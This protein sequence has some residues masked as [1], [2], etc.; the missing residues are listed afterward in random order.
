M[1]VFNK[2]IRKIHLWLGL[3]CGLIA[4]FSGLTGALYVWQ[5][6]ITGILNPGLLKVEQTE[7][8][9]E[10]VIL[11]SAETLIATHQDSIGKIFLPYRE[12]QTISIRFKNG[13]TNYYHPVTT[14]NLGEKS[15][16]ISFFE[17]LLNLHRTLGIPKIGKYIIGTS[18]IIFFLFLLTSGAY[19][20]W[21]AYGNNL[22]E[23]L[24][25]KWN[26]K[27]R[28]LDLDLHKVLGICFFIPLLVMAFTGSYFTYNSYYKA[29]LK[30]F[31]GKSNKV[32]L[33]HERKQAVKD[34]LF[35]KDFSLK[36][37]ESYALRAIYF[38]Q[39][40]TGVYRFRYIKEGFIKAGLRK[41]KEVEINAKGKI[42][43]L[44]DFRHDSNS[45]RIAAQFYPVHIGEIAGLGGRILVFISGM[46]PLVLFITGFR[47]YRS[48]K[49]PSKKGP[50]IGK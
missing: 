30:V 4:S 15:A 2:T 39:D 20:W 3:S 23:G 44:S 33:D 38:P 5:P 27:R 32:G 16:S 13:Q 19:I 46:V 8:I 26:G 49:R 18:T 29:A 48:K 45:T 11:R 1:I 12:Q 36:A 7:N 37:D 6:E 9:K 24:K 41:T 17:N 40:G 42:T 47:M 22:R 28:K 14:K 50:K 21:R 10:A 34:S 43:T 35:L 25:I 31:D